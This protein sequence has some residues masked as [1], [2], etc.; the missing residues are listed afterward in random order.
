MS[1][2]QTPRVTRLESEALSLPPAAYERVPVTDG[3]LAEAWFDAPPPSTRRSSVPPAPVSAVGEFLGDP[4]V[5]A[6]LR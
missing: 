2:P 1:N 3:E 6:W 5:D 4:L